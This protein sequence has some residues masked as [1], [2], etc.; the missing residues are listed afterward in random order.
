[1][2]QP[3]DPSYQPFSGY[4]RALDAREDAELTHA[5]PRTP[6]GEY[7]RRF[8]HPVAMSSQIGDVPLVVTLLGEELVLFRD[9]G[10]RIG[11]LHKH[12]S[13]R[14]AS[15]EYGIRAE[16]GIRC[17]Y[18]G[19]LYDIDG[20]ILE[21]PG[22]PANS[23]IRDTIRHGAY[24]TLNYKGLVFAYLGPPEH[25]PEFPVFDTF[26]LPDNDLVPYSI[27]Y[28]CNW[29]Q[30]AENPMDPFH[31]VFLH[32]RVTRAHFNPAWGALPVVEW[33][34]MEHEAGVYLTNTRRWG[35]YVW[36]RTAEVI[37]PNFAQ[38]PDIYQDPDREKFFPR[39]GISKW[40]VP[41][42][43]TSC[44]IIGWRHFNDTLDL[45]G[46]GDRGKVGLNKIDFL[47]QT[48]S[49]RSYEEGQRLPGDYEAQIGQGPIA[50]HAGEMLGTTDT[51]VAILRRMLRQGIRAVQSG[52]DLPALP[53]N[54]AGHIPTMAGDVIL[55]HP[56]SNA[57]DLAAQRD[58]GR[59]V[60]EVV[61]AT[62]P[63]PHGERQAEIERRIRAMFG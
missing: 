4:H 55:R 30:V 58:I 59:R 57:D 35:E 60:G 13:H 51:G 23:P 39:V 28:P 47:G 34:K 14:R 31:S 10:G 6:C 16:R 25:K 27:D 43:D 24:P 63:L 48:G 61:A 54:A 12:C 50:I 38:P 17:C 11:L 52:Q 18:H 29:L 21:T 36:A 26:E 7:M 8:W 2:T 33:H 41:V 5:G 44:K 22:E 49:E 42:D 1:V 40:T 3:I 9:L 56:T 20:R 62:R 45:G 53:R 37:M 32:T 19:W 15:L 46:K